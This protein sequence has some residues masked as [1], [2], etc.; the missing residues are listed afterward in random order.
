MDEEAVNDVSYTY[1]LPSLAD[2]GNVI[3]LFHCRLP[4]WSHAYNGNN[5]GARSYSTLSLQMTLRAP[6]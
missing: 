2:L 3:T 6:S 1:S 4:E 5:E